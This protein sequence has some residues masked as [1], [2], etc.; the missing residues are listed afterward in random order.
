[1]L[2]EGEYASSNKKDKTVLYLMDRNFLSRLKGRILEA[3]AMATD[4]SF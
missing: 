1:M 2:E 3:V 4:Q